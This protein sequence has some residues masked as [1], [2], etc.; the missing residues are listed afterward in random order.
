MWERG[1]PV[2]CMI[3]FVAP[4][5]IKHKK[6]FDRTSEKKTCLC[7]LFQLQVDNNYKV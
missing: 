6:A 3:L 2:L 5:L 4:D 1:T 7:E